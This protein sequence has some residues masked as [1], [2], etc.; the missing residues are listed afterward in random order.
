M[1]ILETPPRM[2]AAGALPR[3]LSSIRRRSAGLLAGEHS[4][5]QVALGLAAGVFAAFPP[6]FGCQLVLAAL[7]ARLLGASTVAALT[8]TFA[9]NPVTWPAIWAGSYG[10]GAALIGE[11]VASMDGATEQLIRL[12]SQLSVD[13]LLAA[14]QLARPM[15]LAM[16][17]GSIPLG[18]AAALAVYAVAR[19]AIRDT[20]TG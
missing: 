10:L 3:L 17:L 20:G 18:G 1:Q 5:H 11:P 16:V 13:S 9:G 14:W 8:G 2:R 12:F 6:V 4:S 15:L 7:L 19:S